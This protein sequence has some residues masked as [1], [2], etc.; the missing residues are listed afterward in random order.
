M[1]L[2]LVRR[3]SSRTGAFV[4]GWGFGFGWFLAGL[5]WV[6]IAFY[7][8]AER[9]GSLAVPAVLLLA[10]FLAILPGLACLAVALPSWTS[11]RAQALA[12][13]VAWTLAEMARGAFGLRFPWN[14]VAIVWAGSDAMLQSVAWI[15]QWGLSLVTVAAATL[16]AAI[17]DGHGARRWIYPGIGVAILAL[18]LAAGSFRLSGSHDLAPQPAELRIVQGNISQDL[19]WDDARRAEWLHRH[20]ELTVRSEPAEPD[21]V[22][23][24][25]TAVPYQLERDANAREAVASVAPSGGYVLTGGN[26]YN[27]DAEPPTANNSLFAI[28]AEGRIDGRYDKVD[29]VPFG[30][31]LPFRPVLSLIGLRK[32]TEGTLDFVPGPGRQTLALPGLPAFSPLICYEAIFPVD[33]APLDPRPTWLLNVT[34][35]AWFGR[36]SGP[37]QHLAMARLRAIEEGLP[38]VRAANT[39]ISAVIDAHGRVTASLPLGEAGVIDAALPGALPEPPPIRRWHGWITAALMLLTIGTSLS[40]ER[41]AN[42]HAQH[43]RYSGLWR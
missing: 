21:A 10:G 25:E 5:Y 43:S 12:L 3:A 42:W 11:V 24:P 39:G 28:D 41:R 36:S 2:L 22:I 14:P 9:F 30:E 1:L 20:L 40:V 38:L 17:V 29:L 27:L 7:A 35:D 19:K 8:D 32:V 31:F 37:Y 4:V 26:R 13:A 15:G 33:A 34:N 6:G 18:L 23:W 16:F